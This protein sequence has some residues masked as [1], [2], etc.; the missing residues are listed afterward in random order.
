MQILS[1]NDQMYSLKKESKNSSAWQ[2]ESWHKGH[3]YFALL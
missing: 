3:L 2:G 1:K